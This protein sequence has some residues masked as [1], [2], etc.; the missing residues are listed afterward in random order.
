MIRAIFD[1]LEIDNSRNGPSH[2][3][4]NMNSDLSN[5]FSN[6]FFWEVYSITSVDIS[7]ITTKFVEN[8]QLLNNATK[9]K[10]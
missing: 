8:A 9:N 1:V 7:Y 4:T 6:R 10:K 2:E 5:L 3:D